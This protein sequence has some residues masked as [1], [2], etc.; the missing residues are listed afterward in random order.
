MSL[1]QMSCNGAVMIAAIIVIRTLAINR[2]PKTAFFLLWNVTLIRLLIPFSLPSQFSIYTL[3]EKLLNAKPKEAVL[4]TSTAIRVTA[5]GTGATE[6]FPWMIVIWLLGAVVLAG[7]HGV[8][9]WKCKRDFNEALPVKND[10]VTQWLAQNPCKRNIAIRQSDRISAPLTYGILK[11]V[12]LVPK[13]MPWQDSNAVDCILQHELTHIRRLDALAKLLLIAVLC[14]HWFNPFVWMM[15]VIANQDLELSCDEAVIQRM[16]EK[17]KASY[18]LTLINMEEKKCGRTP[19]CSHFSN[20]SIE[21]RIVSIMNMKKTSL[22]GIVLTA[23]LVLGTTTAFATS[24]KSTP[25]DSVPAAKLTAASRVNDSDDAKTVAV[26]KSAIPAIEVVPANSG[27]LDVEILNVDSVAGDFEN[28]LSFEMGDPMT[29]E[30]F[31]KWMKKQEAEL[32]A[33]VAAGK[34]SKAD[35]QKEIESNQQVLQNIKKGDKVYV[36]TIDGEDVIITMMDA[37]NATVSVAGR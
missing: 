31:S 14:I 27:E 2:L 36:T 5:G 1:F 18:A 4:A 6:P 37:I 7:Y 9:Y 22:L 23:A 28:T 26:P 15:V 34:I 19:M 20:N 3:L 17:I 35:A 29:A 25:T 16:G 12:I 10:F 32:N 24:A 13:K 11:P 21:E 30:S 8:V 33:D